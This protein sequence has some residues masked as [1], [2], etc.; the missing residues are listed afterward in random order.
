M[1]RRANIVTSSGIHSVLT[2][3]WLSQDCFLILRTFSANVDIMESYKIPFRG[4][5]TGTHHFDLE[6][7]TEFFEINKSA[8]II[9]GKVS[10]E[11]ELEKQER[12]LVF[13]FILTGQVTV[14]CDRCN[15]PVGIPVQGE[16]RLIVKFGDS[17]EEQS[18]EVQVIPET[19]TRIDVSTFIYEYIHLLMPARR[20]H[21][22]DEQGHSTC[23]PLVLK[24]LDELTQVPSADP[25][26]DVLL[27]L[28]NPGPHK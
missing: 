6:A 16:K 3:I 21:P 15:E 7:G 27:K 4:L 26:W 17:Y 12:M 10:V 13:R 28:K 1:K 14:L 2:C 22:D 9:T 24:K 20:V 25:R 23:D 8:Q 11:V 19:I 5:K 18:D